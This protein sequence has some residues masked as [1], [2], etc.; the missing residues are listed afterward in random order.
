MFLKAL[1][2]GALLK[3][4]GLPNDTDKVPTDKH[5]GRNLNFWLPTWQR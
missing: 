1:W 5:M 3:K 2:V 4:Y